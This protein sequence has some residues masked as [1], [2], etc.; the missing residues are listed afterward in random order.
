MIC[1]LGAP[2]RRS[3]SFFPVRTTSCSGD[4]GGPLVAPTPG[5]PRLVGVVSAG[6]IPCGFAPSIYARIS[7]GRRFVEREL[8][9]P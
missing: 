9:R 4:S 6:P 7:A 3:R 5:G 2:F 1:A 8:A